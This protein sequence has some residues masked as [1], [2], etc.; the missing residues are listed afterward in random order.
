MKSIVL[1]SVAFGLV[2]LVAVFG[3]ICVDVFFLGHEEEKFGVAW[4]TVQIGL[5]LY[6]ILVARSSVPLF[7]ALLVR[8]RLATVS[9]LQGLRS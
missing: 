4:G 5:Y 3:L 6:G 2:L 8:G 1:Y 7:I 9:R